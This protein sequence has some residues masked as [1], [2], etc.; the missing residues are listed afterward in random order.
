MRKGYWIDH[1]R[2]RLYRYLKCP[3][4]GTLAQIEKLRP[5]Y[6]YDIQPYF[7]FDRAGRISES[8]YEI[9][10]LD[11]TVRHYEAT[12]TSKQRFHDRRK[13]LLGDPIWGWLAFIV[14]AVVAV[15]G[16]IS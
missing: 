12:T 2:N 13:E 5:G 6:G 11:M 3:A 7:E 4:G 14:T 15:V 1:D 8:E 10:L 9:V 16:W